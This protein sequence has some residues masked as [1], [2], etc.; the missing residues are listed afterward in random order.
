M[1]TKQLVIGDTAIRMRSV[2]QRK[3][4]YICLNDIAAQAKAP[5]DKAILHFMRSRPNLNFLA[6]WERFHNSRFQESV[7]TKIINTV[8]NDH[9]MITVQ[10]WIDQ[11]NAIGMEQVTGRYGGI[12]VHPDIAIAFASW[13]DPQVKLYLIKEFQR[14]KDEEIPQLQWNLR[15]ELSKINYRLH[16][17]S[18][19]LLMPPKLDDLGK[20]HLHANEADLL[21]M[22]LFGL[23]AM[24]WR[25][26][27]PDLKGNMRDYASLEQLTVL[28]NLETLNAYLIKSGL[29]ADERLVLLNTE[30]ISQMNALLKYDALKRMRTLE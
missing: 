11:T 5:V 29:E 2:E 4:D 12:Y 3:E 10:D 8:V 27:N 30:A 9:F 25:V 17:D 20:K 1:K 18:I 23:N 15:R 21:N 6:E 28:S 14:L 7:F 22:A 24:E 13:L 16:A 26:Q 19:K